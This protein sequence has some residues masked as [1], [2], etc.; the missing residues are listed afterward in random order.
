MEWPRAW[1]ILQ[2][3]VLWVGRQVANVALAG[4]EVGSWAGLT[5]QNLR[6]HF[7][8]SLSLTVTLEVVGWPHLIEEGK[9]GFKADT[10]NPVWLW[11]SEKEKH[12]MD[13]WSPVLPPECCLFLLCMAIGF[14]ST[15]QHQGWVHPTTAFLWAPLLV[16]K[17][18]RCSS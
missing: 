7:C 16:F 1:L 6:I 2:Q 5:A 14:K 17:Q 3:A 4:A 13:G 15:P 9:E 18:S 10:Q 8:A 12:R 11:F